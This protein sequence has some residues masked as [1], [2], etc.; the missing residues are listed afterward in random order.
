MREA[1][2]ELNMTIFVII[3]I[4][5]VAAFLLNTLLPGIFD[6]IRDEW[7]KQKDI[8]PT[9]YIEKIDVNKDYYIF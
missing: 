4:G 7:L 6:R 5:V 8:Q 3:A 2:G 1:A 9:G